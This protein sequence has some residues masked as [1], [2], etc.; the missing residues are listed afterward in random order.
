MLMIVMSVALVGIATAAPPKT[1][2]KVHQPSGKPTKAS[3]FAPHPT[4]S[5]VFGAPI[6]A[7]ILKNA[8]PK[9]PAPK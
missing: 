3:S 7:P 8:P 5:R 6:Q 4:R 2:S 1:L 9:K